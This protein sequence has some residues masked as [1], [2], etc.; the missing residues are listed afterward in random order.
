MKY[1]G[2]DSFANPQQ[3]IDDTFKFVANSVDKI[4]DDSEVWDS[5]T[6]TQDEYVSFIEQLSSKQFA[7]VQ[8]FFDTMPTL[9]HK[10]K[11]KNPNTNV[12][13]DYVIEGLTNFFA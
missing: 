13:F 8:R 11:A 2:I 7:D 1:P 6:T 3:D 5:N 9:R 4:Y 12:E 10:I